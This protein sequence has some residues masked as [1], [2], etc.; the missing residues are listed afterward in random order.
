[1]VEE[2]I[3]QVRNIFGQ[4]CDFHLDEKAA[5]SPI[6]QA[7]TSDYAG[8]FKNNFIQRLKR[9]NKIY[10]EVDSNRVA[11]L[12]LLKKVALKRNW[13]GAFAELSAYDYLNLRAAEWQRP[14]VLNKVPSVVTLA[15]YW[16]KGK[17]ADIDCYFEDF[18]VY[19][20]VKVL[21]DNVKQLLDGIYDDL[22]Q[23]LGRSDF[24]ISEDRPLDLDSEVIEHHR[25]EVLNELINV[26]EKSERP[27]VLRSKV[28]PQILFRFTW[29]SGWQGSFKFYNPY[30]HAQASHKLAFKHA[31]KY[32]ERRPFLLL[33]VVFPWFN[34][35]ISSFGGGNKA[36]YRSF[37]RRVFCGYMRRRTSFK[38]LEP[39]FNSDLTIRSVSK[40]LSGIIFLEDYS[41]TS[42]DESGKTYSAY[43]YMNPNAD[44][45]VARS[46]FRNYLFSLPRIEYDDFEFDNY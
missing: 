43:V 45:S 19:M 33:F 3:E 27:R 31:K 24:H 30:L 2:Y 39:D 28:I 23:S 4:Q 36:F 5:A 26:F 7:F 41:L 17:G 15:R 22:K 29:E 1:M 35:V 38:T 12:T 8:L 44:N 9:L 46:A 21:A 25:A 18:D 16:G 34:G 13:A 6:S 42:S 20:D 32:V 40:K 37:S 10:P 11:L 14:M